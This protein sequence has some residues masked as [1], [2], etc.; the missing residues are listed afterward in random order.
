MRDPADNYGEL[1]Q[2]ATSLAAGRKA[3]VSCSSP[4]ES[5]HTW[6]RVHTWRTI[7]IGSRKFA[8]ATVSTSLL[9]PNRG[10]R[11]PGGEIPPTAEELL[12]PGGATPEM[13]SKQLAEGI[14]GISEIYNDFDFAVTPGPGMFS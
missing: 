14:S 8:L 11:K 7:E 2:R 10:A 6:I 12:A 5:P 9:F 1:Y 3:A 4:G 13:L